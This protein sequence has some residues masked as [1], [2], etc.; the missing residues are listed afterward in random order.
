MLKLL[1][2]SFRLAGSVTTNEF[3]LRTTAARME[4]GQCSSR[5]MWRMKFGGQRKGISQV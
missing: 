3:S 1:T 5:E 2:S 4:M